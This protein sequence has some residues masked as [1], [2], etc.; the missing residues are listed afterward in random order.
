[1]ALSIGWISFGGHWV[2]AAYLNGLRPQIAAWTDV[3]LIFVRLGVWLVGGI[4]VC[5]GAIS[6]RP[7]LSGGMF[8]N[9]SQIHRALVYG[10][11]LFAIIELLPHTYLWLSGRPSFWNRRG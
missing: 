6:T 3:S 8:P 1:M 5:L 2:E 4:I 10:G 7:I 11:P 9:P